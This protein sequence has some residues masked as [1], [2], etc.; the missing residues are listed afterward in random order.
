MPEA[1]RAQVEEPVFSDHGTPRATVCFWREQADTVW[2]AGAVEP[3][4]EGVEDGGSVE[5]LF[6]VLLDG[7]PEAYQQ[8]AEEYY[9]VPVGAAAVRRVYALRLLTQGVVSLLNPSVDI[10]GLAED[11]AQIG[12]PV[13]E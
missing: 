5:W 13:Q 2:K 6:D 12:Y 9:E 10:Y 1:F 11:I 3:L 4:P 7:C 8:F